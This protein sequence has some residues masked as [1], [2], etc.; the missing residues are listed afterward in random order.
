MYKYND[1]F[2]MKRTLSPNDIISNHDFLIIRQSF[3]TELMQTK[4]NRRILVG[5][6][7]TFYF[8]NHTT[9]WWQIQEMLRIEK[10]GHEQLQDELAAYAPLVP[11]K[12]GDGSMELVATFM[13]E[14]EDIERR[15]RVLSQ[16][17]GIEHSI[18]LH[19]NEQSV[20]AV[21]ENDIERTNEFG[22]TSAVHFIRFRLS[23]PIIDQFNEPEST[24]TLEITHPCYQHQTRLSDTQKSALAHDFI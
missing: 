24:V 14:I 15:F 23:T 4:R 9:L 21:P 11:Q 17:G 22:K 19:V 2:P 6:D 18:I 20:Q 10:G 1:S 5:D 16:L 7:I 8:E 3:Q 12:F 13:I